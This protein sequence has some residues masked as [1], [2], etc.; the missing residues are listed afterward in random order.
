MKTPQNTQLK[1]PQKRNFNTETNFSN[2]TSDNETVTKTPHNTQK[3]KKKSVSIQDS[4]RLNENI[5]CGQPQK[6]PSSIFER[7]EISTTNNPTFNPSFNLQSNQKSTPIPPSRNCNRTCFETICD[8]NASTLPI[9]TE[10]RTH[11]RQNQIETRISFDNPSNES[12][13]SLC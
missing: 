2:D 10:V 3:N 1:T 4:T 12:F 11:S 5:I 9:N 8:P 13:Y 6:H 7:S